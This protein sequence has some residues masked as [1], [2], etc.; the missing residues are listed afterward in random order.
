VFIAR[1]VEDSGGAT[2]GPKERAMTDYAMALTK[3]PRSIAQEHI[4]KLRDAGLEDEEILHLVLV[5]AYFNF[6]NRLANGLG[7]ELE[8]EGQ[9]R[10]RY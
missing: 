9:T 1:L 8:T 2:L 10:Y 4:T 6:V 5:T 3:D 7:V